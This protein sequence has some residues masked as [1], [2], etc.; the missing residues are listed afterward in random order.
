MTNQTDLKQATVLVVDDEPMLVEIFAEWLVEAGFHVLTAR[1]GAEAL[2]VLSN[3]Q[4][5][6]I[7]TDVRM[8]V[9]DGPA[10]LRALKASGVCLPKL[11]FVT[12]FTDLELREAYDLGVE[13]V[14]HKPI[15]MKTFV[16]AIWRVLR[17]RRQ[18]WSQ[19][20]AAAGATLCVDLPTVPAAIEQGWIAFGQ[21]GICLR[22]DSLREEPVRF[23]LHFESEPLPLAGQGVVRWVDRGERQI[24]IEILSLDDACREQALDLIAAHADFSYIPRA[25]RQSRAQQ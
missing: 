21:G 1:N 24:G 22:N 6:V 19:P 5:D 25:C 9:M 16:G 12:G 8:P 17:P 11:I 10:L 14:L 20:V 2:K 4:V 7:V 18:A 15:D 13:T 23:A 3:Q